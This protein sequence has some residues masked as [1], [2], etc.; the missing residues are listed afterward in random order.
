MDVCLAFK[1]ECYF[2]DDGSINPTSQ[3]VQ[4]CK[5][6]FGENVT[7]EIMSTFWF[8]YDNPMLLMND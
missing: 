2:L 4:R 7:K 8:W 3:F 1:G 6:I 5:E